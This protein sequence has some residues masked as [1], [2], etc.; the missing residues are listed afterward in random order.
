VSKP[1]KC[2]CRWCYGRGNF[3]GHL[4]CEHCDGSGREIITRDEAWS[5]T[6]EPNEKWPRFS[7]EVPPELADLIDAAQRK[8]LGVDAMSASRA[9]CTRAALRLYLNALDPED[10]ES[11]EGT[12][13]EHVERPGLPPARSG[14]SA[15]GEPLPAAHDSE[16]DSR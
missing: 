5:R 3:G 13:R 9:S 8:S 6:K 7:T 1:I 15:H 10:E 16:E 12:A 11:I 14:V 4:P 2:R